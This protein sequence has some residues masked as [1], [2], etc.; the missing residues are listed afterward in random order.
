MQRSRRFRMLSGSLSALARFARRLGLDRRGNY[1]MIVAILLPVITGFVALGTESGLWLYDQQVEQTAADNAAFSAAVYYAGQGAN[2]TSST[3]SAAEGQAAAVAANFGFGGTATSATTCS[4]V[5]GGQYDG[6]AMT[7]TSCSASNGGTSCSVVSPTTGTSCIQVDYPPAQGPNK[8]LANCPPTSASSPCFIEVVI[9]QQPQQLFSRLLLSNPV[10]ISARAVGEVTFSGSSTTQNG[11]SCVLVTDS[12]SS[13]GAGDDA[14]AV[15]FGANASLSAPNCNLAV[16]DTNTGGLTAGSNASVTFSQIYDDASS[17]A[18][19]SITSNATVK[20]TTTFGADTVNPYDLTS[21]PTLTTATSGGCGFT[22]ILTGTFTSGS[23]TVTVSSATGITVGMFAVAPTYLP[24]TSPGINVVTAVS[25]TT[26]TLS[27]KALATGSSKPIQFG[28]NANAM[29]LTASTTLYAGYYLGI[30]ALSTALVQ[31]EPGTYYIC[32]IPTTA[33]ATAAV[34]SS[35]SPTVAV[36][37]GTLPSG[38]V[39][40]MVLKDTANDIPANTVIAGFAIY[41]TLST[42]ATK[43]NTSD[44]F[45]VSSSTATGAVLSDSTTSNAIEF[46]SIPSWSSGSITDSGGALASGSSVT[47]TTQ[48]TMGTPASGTDASDTLSVTGAGEFT[49]AGSAIFY[50][51]PYAA[52]SGSIVLP[53]P[54]SGSNPYSTGCF[55]DGTDGVTIVLLGS[56]SSTSVQPTNCASFALNGSSNAYLVPPNTSGNP[57]GFNGIVITSTQNCSP[58]AIGATTGA[59]TLD[60]AGNSSLEI[61][62]AIDLGQY[63][64][65]LG[66]NANNGSGCLQVIAHSLALTGNTTLG[67]NCT[68]VGTSSIDQLNSG[69]AGTY[70]AALAN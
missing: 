27:Q 4:A 11:N 32:P 8:G 17:I 34:S 13:G 62:G 66:G 29:A 3:M 55:V 43:T 52:S 38:W 54:C 2:A 20:G 67:Q 15:T 41:G 36:V 21:I 70:S 60:I 12:T 49:G 56:S 61:F 57:T 24:S 59:A 14:G 33:T 63:A 30:N 35:S 26:I 16:N 22:P 5:A 18:S 40:G 37:S 65:S 50:T 48:V 51:A 68:G 7:T 31:L 23:S 19:G 39:T 53:S 42:K 45:T 6:V 28:P 64:V 69:A 46:T 1:S 25:G 58:A 44:T 47:V 9:S 10:T